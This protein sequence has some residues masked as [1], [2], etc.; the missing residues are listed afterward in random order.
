MRKF[1]LYYDKDLEESWLQSMC[2]KGWALQSF[3]LGV[4][5]FEPCEPGE[6]IYRID[7]MPATF[8][9]Q[10]AFLAF[11]REL[12]VEPVDKWYRW[13]YLRRRAAEGPFELY[14]DAESQIALYSRI[15]R[16]F[17]GAL[18]LE[19]ICLMIELT[20]ALQT[21]EPLFWAFSGLLFALVLGFARIVK[22]CGGKIR[23]LQGQ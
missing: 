7:L 3:V 18:I 4:Y 15:R 9:E 14:S 23:R 22:K 6:Y 19:S 1:K 21:R 10:Q 11:M 20:A 16:F 13:C 8:R 12:G 17:L 5:T 2:E